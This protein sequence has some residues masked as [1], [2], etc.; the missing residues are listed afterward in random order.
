MQTFPSSLCLIQISFPAGS[1]PDLCNSLMQLDAPLPAAL[2]RPLQVC[3]AQVAVP[4]SGVLFFLA[5]S[6]TV[7]LVHL[8]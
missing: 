3:S 5:A 7:Q 1:P 2:S 4:S 8:A 6:E